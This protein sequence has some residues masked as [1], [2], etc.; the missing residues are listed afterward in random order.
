MVIR[1]EQNAM[2][3]ATELSAENN[4]VKNID[5]TISNLLLAKGLVLTLVKK[6]IHLHK[7]YTQKPI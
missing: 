1:K 2:A 5:A 7:S 4:R 3:N 6:N